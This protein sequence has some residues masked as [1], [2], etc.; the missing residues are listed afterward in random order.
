M[1]DTLIPTRCTIIQLPLA[2]VHHVHHRYTRTYLH[3]IDWSYQKILE[4]ETQVRYMMPH[5]EH[6]IPTTGV[7][8][9]QSPN[10]LH[11]HGGNTND[12]A[13]WH[14]HHN[15]QYNHSITL[16]DMHVTV[17][18]SCLCP[19]TM[20]GPPPRGDPLHVLVLPPLA[21]APPTCV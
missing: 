18:H 15:V 12:I 14:A 10:V 13:S 17:K 19:S 9:C 21:D 11:R 20:R 6:R 3:G 7:V 1:Q 4:L 8:K 16:D 2:L 5:Q